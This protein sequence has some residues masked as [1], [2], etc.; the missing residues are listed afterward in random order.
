MLLGAVVDYATAAAMVLG[1]VLA[2]AAASFGLVSARLRS[3]AHM[4][5]AAGA[6]FV[7]VGVVIEVPRWLLVPAFQDR[8][9]ELSGSADPSVD[10]FA[11]G[12][13]VGHL[14]FFVGA[15]ALVLTLLSLARRPTAVV[16]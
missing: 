1:V 12:L 2:A 14:A 3:P 16:K 13:D 6:G 15:V 10:R 4:G 11:A 8:R 5:A 9:A 7:G